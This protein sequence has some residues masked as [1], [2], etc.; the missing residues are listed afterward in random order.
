MVT[1]RYNLF[2][3]FFLLTLFP[4]YVESGDV[5][6]TSTIHHQYEWFPSESAD[7][8]Y[9]MEIVRGDLVYPNG[10]SIYIPE[11]KVINNGWGEV[12]S[13]HIVGEDLKP[14]PERLRIVWFSYTENKFFA[15]DTPLPYDALVHAFGNGIVSPITGEKTR[16]DRI[17]VGLGLDG[18]V[19]IWVSGE[20]LTREIAIFKAEESNVEWATFFDDVNMSREA[21][22]GETLTQYIGVE[23]YKQIQEG[24]VPSKRWPLYLKRYQWQLHTSGSGE[25]QDIR[26]YYFNGEKEY[27]SLTNH[28]LPLEFSNHSAPKR[29]DIVWRNALGK[30]YVAEIYLNENEIFCEFERYL[31]AE[32]KATIHFKI[33]LGN[34]AQSLGLSL[35]C[36]NHTGVLKAMRIDVYSAN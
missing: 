18:W 8:R 36:K 13:I 16:Y 9:P 21:I 1:V 12:G 34:R 2:F 15:I 3:M 10:D 4:G 27:Y 32:P 19:S 35:G 30:K 33:E 31:N 29:L 14:I 23:K 26:L 11:K 20:W 17:I 5:M 6:K 24:G 22:I 28:K 7:K 25:L